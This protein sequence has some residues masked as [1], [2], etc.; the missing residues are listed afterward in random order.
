MK[1]VGKIGFVQTVDDGHGVWRQDV[2]ER[3]YKGDL[4]R[5]YKN[6]QNSESVNDNLT[7]SNNLSI[8]ADKFVTEQLSMMKYVKLRGSYWSITSADI[9]PPRII[10][11]LGGV[12]NGPTAQV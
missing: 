10:L 6:Y 11:T 12:Y 8:I 5:N 4:V 3:T 2:I 1:F 9:Q 7:L